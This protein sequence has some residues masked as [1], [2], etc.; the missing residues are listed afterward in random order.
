MMHSTQLG[1]N[2]LEMHILTLS[3]FF[4]TYLPSNIDWVNFQFQQIKL[5]LDLLQLAITMLKFDDN[6][7]FK[8]KIIIRVK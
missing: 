6:F 2:N 3:D 8:V 4:Q 1:S 7:K 5:R